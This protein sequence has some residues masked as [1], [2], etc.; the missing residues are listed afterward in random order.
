MKMG[1]FEGYTMTFPYLKKFLS[2]NEKCGSYD[3]SKIA[4]PKEG[5]FRKKSLSPYSSRDK[6]F[7]KYQK[8]LSPRLQHVAKKFFEKF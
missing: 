7:M 3:F 1:Y 8:A 4:L 5:K 6:K 2:Y